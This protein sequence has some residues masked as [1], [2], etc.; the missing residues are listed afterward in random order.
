MTKT[1]S[2]VVGTLCASF[3]TPSAI[4]ATPEFQFSP[5]VGVGSLSVDQYASVNNAPDD[6]RTV[7]VG[8]GFGY[9]TAPGIVLEI[10]VDDF[11]NI[12]LLSF[13]DDFSLH[14]Q[15]ASV[16]YQAELGRGW[17][18][19]PRVGYAR[20]KLRSEES[21][22]F[23]PGPEEVRKVRGDDQF[24]ELGLYRRISRVVTLGMSYKQGNYEFG[25]TRTTVFNVTMGF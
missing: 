24:W 12:N 9:L 21:P 11:G 23:N 6:T 17:R 10:G 19:V 16:G 13:E 3:V 4:S 14:Q 5:R 18:L 1:L 2:A 20:W 7:G 8:F 15:F 22:L 25:D